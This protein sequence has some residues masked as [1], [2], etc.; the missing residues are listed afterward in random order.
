MFRRD[1]EGWREKRREKKCERKILEIG[2]KNY[3]C[4]QNGRKFRKIKWRI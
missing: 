1:E 2:L 4:L 3:K